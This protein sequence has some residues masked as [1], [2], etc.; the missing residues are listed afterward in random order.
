MAIELGTPALLDPSE[1][2][3]YLA[4]RDVRASGTLDVDG[5]NVWD[6]RV[7][8]ETLLE[9]EGIL[10][11][12]RATIEHTSKDAATRDDLDDLIGRLRAVT[13]REFGPRKRSRRGEGGKSKILEYLKGHVG[14][15]V[16]GEELAAISGIQEWPRRTREWRTE[17]GYDIEEDGGRYRLKSLEP[18]TEIAARWRLANAIRRKPGAAKA[19]LLEFLIANEGT[20]VDRGELDYVADKAKES[21]RRLRELRDE[22]GW[23]IESHIDDPLLKPG[24]YRLVSAA[25][26]DRRDIR[27]RLY[28]EDLRERIFERDDYTCRRC[29][30][31]RERAEKAGDSRFYLE[32]HHLNAVADQLDGLTANA[33]NDESNLITYCHRDHLEE[34]A[35]LQRRRRA[36]RRG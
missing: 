21:V 8:D 4:D 34:T 27:Q 7:N 28:P 3:A 9:L 36:E 2:R 17:E 13:V 12:F 31:N 16:Q 22:E 5:W 30:R 25:D 18:N 1:R 20:V 29:G 10:S 35:R 32:V 19:R 33:L 15:W 23:P 14:E 24:Q 11:D 26:E 6:C